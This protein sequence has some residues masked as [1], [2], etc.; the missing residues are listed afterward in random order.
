MKR[1]LLALQFLTIFPVRIK[2]GIDEKDF[3]A[4]L[5]YF[6]FVGLLIG[7]F[8]AGC[9]FIFSFLP[10]LVRAALILIASIIISGGIHLDGF[11]DVCDGFYG[12]KPKEII[13]EIM[14][15][16]HAGAI[17]VIGLSALLLL[18]FSL[19][20][21]IPGELLYKL[22]IFMAVFSRYCQ[23]VSSSF[24]DY[25]RSDGKAKYFV[26]YAGIREFL[27]ATVFTLALLLFLLKIK[28]IILFCLCLFSILLFISWIKRKIGGMT[29][30][31]IG[32][33]SEIAEVLVLLFGLVLI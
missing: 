1:L 17:A 27:I 9:V 3:G 31:T 26:E 7:L 20:V 24:S 29:G 25:A 15:D 19:L 22:L 2:A 14:R 32:A 12:N 13:L 8:L 16:S 5:V 33:V 28:G 18:K 30:D 21:S 23:V 10:G 6:P 4:S 11:A